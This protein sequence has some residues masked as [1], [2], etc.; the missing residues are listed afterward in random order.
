MVSAA[1][2]RERYDLLVIAEGRR[3]RTRD[4]AFTSPAGYRDLGQY[5][6]YGTIDRRAGDD[7]WWHWM[8]ATGARTAGIRPDDLGTLRAHLSFATPP[9]GFESLPREAQFQVLAERLDP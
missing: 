7:D 5:V 9:F 8:T 1:G 6:A 3:S 2:R 4:L